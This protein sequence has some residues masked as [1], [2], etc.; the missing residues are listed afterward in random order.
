TGYLATSSVAAALALL[1]GIDDTPP[2][3]A[4]YVLALLLGTTFS[5]MAPSAGALV[6]NAVSVGD[7]ASAISIQAAVQNMTRIAGPI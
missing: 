3:W 5:L 1:T 2:M 6:V 7:I 4:I